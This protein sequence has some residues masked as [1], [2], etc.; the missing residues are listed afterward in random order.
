MTFLSLLFRHKPK[1]NGDGE[2]AE[3]DKLPLG[4][5]AYY[6]V[7]GGLESANRALWTALWFAFTIAFLALLLL[8]LK[9]SQPPV[10]IRVDGSGQAEISVDSGVQPP[11][12]EVEIKNFLTLFERFFTELNC[13]TYTSDLKLAFTMMTSDFQAKANDML[14]RGGTL[15]TL[16]A[17]EDRTTVTLTEIL[18]VRDTPHVFECH[19]K[20]YREIGSYKPDGK[21]NEVVFDDDVV[22]RKVPRSQQ[23][24]YGVLVENY[25]E[26]VFKR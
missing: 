4:V 21:Q 26:S 9:I 18:I 1:S 3:A 20:G 23:A 8:R 6:E 19:V 10:V 5:P 15:E 24:P 2:K 16:K 11:V 25:N 7:W 17:N 12:S 13:Y 14:A 22:L